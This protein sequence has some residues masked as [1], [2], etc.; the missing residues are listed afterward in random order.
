V[1]KPTDP[2][3]SLGLAGILGKRKLVLPLC[4]AVWTLSNLDQ[5]LFGYAVP[6][7][8][9]EFHLRLQ[10]VGVILTISFAAGAGMVVLSGIA[11]DRFGK[12][13]TLGL[14]LGLSALLVG[15]QAFA[16]NIVWLTLL[17]AL[18]FGFSSGLAPITNALVAENANARTRG[19]AMGLLQCGYPLGW[20]FA[21]LFAA[22]LLQRYGWRSICL[23]AL[24]VVPL[25]AI[26]PF[27][28]GTGPM[29]LAQGVRADRRPLPSRALLSSLFAPSLRR[30]SLAT[31]AIFFLFGGAYAGSVFF[32]PLFFVQARHYTASNAASLV[33]ISNGIA[34]FGYMGA[35]L[36]GEFLI[37]RRNVFVLWCLGGAAGLIGLLWFS[38][39]A[40][41]DVL[42]YGAT[43]ALFFGSQAVVIVL[44][45]ELFPAQVRTTGIA[46]CAS[47]PVNL[48]F[49]TFP[50]IVPMVVGAVGWRLGMSLT[51]LPPLIGAGLC[52]LLLQ[53]R[54]SGLA[55]D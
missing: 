22:P 32:F 6:G 20:L 51:I 40:A 13:I 9:A 5:G 27:F 19:L 18:G 54:R 45:S 7:I 29:R 12:E 1:D 38:K 16:S 52:G 15:L 36:F 50:M 35:A 10:A 28:L 25:A 21:S 47:A 30:T 11:A 31:M 48:G 24:P 44:V 8:L 34:V 23:V 17:R 41:Q 43:A 14:L 37:T 53:N 55:I 3:Q 4:L 46:L 33:G 39:G 2:D 26:V 42:W 49:A